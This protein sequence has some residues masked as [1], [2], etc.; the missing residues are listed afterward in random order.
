MSGHAIKGN[1]V[2]RP[3]QMQGGGMAPLMLCPHMACLSSVTLG[4]HCVY[5]KNPLALSSVS[6]WGQDLPR[7]GASGP[8]CVAAGI[9]AGRSH[10]NECGIL[11]NVCD[12]RERKALHT[13]SPVSNST[14]ECF[15]KHSLS[16]KGIKCKQQTCS[17]MTTGSQQGTLAPDFS[18]LFPD[19]SELWV[20]VLPVPPAPAFS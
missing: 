7:P 10:K 17:H 5:R 15:K 6:P 12:Q 9:A 14:L 13:G 2:A 16:L 3:V 8:V 19:A 18:E 4:A 20:T 11:G 1:S